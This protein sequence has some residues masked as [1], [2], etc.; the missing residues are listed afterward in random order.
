MSSLWRL[1][2]LTRDRLLRARMRQP[3][4]LRRGE[5]QRIFRST[6]PQGL[7]RDYE[8]GVETRYV[9]WQA[10]PFSLDPKG[11]AAVDGGNG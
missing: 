4:A 11:H 2:D 8:R 9:N 1:A 7:R 10:A 6:Q 3:S 5:H